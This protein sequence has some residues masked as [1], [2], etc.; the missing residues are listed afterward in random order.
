MCS[1][2]IS[3]VDGIKQ[4]QS[5]LRGRQKVTAHDLCLAKLVLKRDTGT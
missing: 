2:V 5:T 3:K 1:S 4:H